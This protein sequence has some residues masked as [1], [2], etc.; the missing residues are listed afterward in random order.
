MKPT[1][2]ISATIPGAYGPDAL[3]IILEDIH[4]FQDGPAWTLINL[5]LDR[6]DE[7]YSHQLDEFIPVTEQERLIDALTKGLRARTRQFNSPAFGFL[8]AI[9]AQAEYLREQQRI[10][11]ENEEG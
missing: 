3:E 10:N 11:G 7:D 9:K 6:Q 2:P 4:K 8:G 5:L 1:E